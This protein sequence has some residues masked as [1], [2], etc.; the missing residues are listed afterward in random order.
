MGKRESSYTVG[1]NVNWCSQL[2]KIAW[3]SFKKL[4]IEVPY[5]PAIPLLG[6][7][8]KKPRTLILKDTC[9][10]VHSSN[11]YKCRNMEAT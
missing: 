4:K 5:D 10:N 1:G 11:I 6:I 9:P 3:R 8:P 7:H 2:W